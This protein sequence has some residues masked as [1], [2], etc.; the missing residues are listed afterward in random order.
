ML[1][2]QFIEAARTARRTVDLDHIVQ[3]AYRALSE[4]VISEAD[5]EVALDAIEAR[6]KIFRDHRAA[7]SFPA[8][9]EPRKANRSPDKQRSIERRR[10]IAQEG[11][12]PRGVACRFT[13]GE[14]AVLSIIAR[15]VQARGRCEMPQDKIAALAGVC[16]SLVRRAIRL[17]RHLGLITVTERRRRGQKN[18]TNVVTIISA[19][20]LAWLKSG[21]R[22]DRG[23]ERNHHE[24]TGYRKIE[25]NTAIGGKLLNARIMP[26]PSSR[27]WG[28]NSSADK[29]KYYDTASLNC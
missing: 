1:A 22:T 19:E 17:A 8:A 21:K 6:R 10:G 13:T 2:T 14:V 23:H 4:G 26:L 29:R 24:K 11:M 18:D 16:R 5:T 28:H 3:L 12:M 25:K 9:G 27:T 7:R 15:E 20:W